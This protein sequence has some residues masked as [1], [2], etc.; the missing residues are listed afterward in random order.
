MVEAVLVTNPRIING[1]PGPAM[2]RLSATLRTGCCETEVKGGVDLG[3]KVG[4]EVICERL[5][6]S[7]KA[8]FIVESLSN[9]GNAILRKKPDPPRS[10]NHV[11]WYPLSW[12]DL[13]ERVRKACDNLNMKWLN[14]FEW[15][16]SDD[17][18]SIN[19]IGRQSLYFIYDTMEEYGLE[20]GGKKE[21]EPLIPHIESYLAHIREEHF[22]ERAWVPW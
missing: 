3:M 16:D 1:R 11:A 8:V 10:D 20:T 5:F 12:V 22:N 13:T 18:I 17:I 6:P 9:N 19:G 7:V 14:E 4:D 2:W 15:L 21:G